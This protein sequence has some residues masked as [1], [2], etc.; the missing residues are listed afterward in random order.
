MG[1]NCAKESKRAPNDLSNLGCAVPGLPPT[2]DRRK[3]V[4][5]PMADQNFVREVYK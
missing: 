3:Y 5:P 1:K 4:R 2:L